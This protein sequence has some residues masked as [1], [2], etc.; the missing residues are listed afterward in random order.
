MSFQWFG[1]KPNRS[2]RQ[3]HLAQTI[4]VVKQKRAKINLDKRIRHQAIRDDIQSASCRS[5]TIFRPK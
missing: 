2:N 3:I 1:K 4:V 5:D